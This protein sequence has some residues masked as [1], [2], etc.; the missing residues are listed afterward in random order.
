MTE[1]SL[2]VDNTGNNINLGK[3]AQNNQEINSLYLFNLYYYFY[4]KGY[5]NLVINEIINL[6]VL[7]YTVFL[8]IFLVQ[9]VNFV[10]L[11]KYDINIVIFTCIWFLIIVF[12][13]IFKRL[14]L[15]HLIKISLYSLNY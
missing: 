14:F 11:I 6:G 13:F 8:L 12:L 7:I 10:D 9:C 4:N 2:L 5:S 15:L 1:Y 3:Y